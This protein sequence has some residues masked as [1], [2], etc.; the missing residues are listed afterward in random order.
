MRSMIRAIP[1]FL[2]IAIAALML[3]PGMLFGQDFISPVQAK[4]TKDVELWTGAVAA[5]HDGSTTFNTDIW[6]AGARFG[7]VLTGPHGSGWLRGTLQW[8]FDVIPIFVVT[9]LQTAY[10]AEFDPISLRWN[11]NHKGRTAPY[12]EMAGGAVLTTAKVPIGDTSKINF[13]PKV[14]FGWQ[15]FRHGQRSIDVGIDA[16]HLSNARTAPRNPSANGILITIG[17]HWF[18]PTIQSATRQDNRGDQ[19]AEGK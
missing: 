12:F 17:Y 9:N 4:G 8:D 1:Q 18:K 14:G 3:G 11:F 5:Q 15:F 16:W 10:G 19:N 2:T 6:M 7:H 13:V